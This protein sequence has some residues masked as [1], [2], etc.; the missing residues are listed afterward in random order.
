[1]KITALGL[2]VS[3]LDRSA[4]FYDKVFGFRSRSGAEYGVVFE[5]NDRPAS[6]RLFDGAG[7]AIDL[8]AVPQPDVSSG[9]QQPRTIANHGITNLTFYHDD[10]DALGKAIERHGGQVVAGSR[11]TLR[12]GVA[13]MFAGD[14]DGIALELISG[15]GAAPGFVH[16]VIAA[17]DLTRSGR[18]YAAL[19][20]SLVREIALPEPADWLSRFTS[21]PDITLTGHVFHNGDGGQIE[22]IN[23]LTPA[24]S[25]ERQPWPLH[26]PGISHFSF[27][28]PDPANLATTLAGLGSQHISQIAEGAWQVLDPDGVRLILIPAR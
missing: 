4:A 11:T 12:P 17:T 6:V 16:A 28:V 23:V 26:I 1:M 24:P 10:L 18:F 8:T 13:G 19:G 22:L 27:A 20:F 21:V 5:S 3:N 2:S 15:S 7:H 14:P 25:G 9:L